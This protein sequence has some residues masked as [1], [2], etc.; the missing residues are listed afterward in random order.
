MFL[1]LCL[2][3]VVAFLFC[4]CFILFVCLFCFDRVWILAESRIWGC[5]T[6]SCSQNIILVYRCFSTLRWIF[7]FVFVPEKINYSTTSVRV[8]HVSA[9]HLVCVAEDDPR[10][11]DDLLCFRPTSW[12]QLWLE[13]WWHC[14]VYG[15]KLRP[16][17]PSLVTGLWT[18]SSIYWLLCLFSI[19][20]R[21][22][23]DIYCWE[24]YLTL[25][26]FQIT[27]IFLGQS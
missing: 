14:C 26:I 4:C 19:I 8:Q 6:K 9:L 5:V 20:Y 10:S 23:N 16:F 22:N 27:V 7:C 15:T 24:Y 12:R 18:L 17:L 13:L 3:V 1:S 21:F 2:C 11:G 25:G